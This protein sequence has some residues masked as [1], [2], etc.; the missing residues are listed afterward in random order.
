MLM[1]DK[2]LKVLVDGLAK[3]VTHDQIRRLGVL[4]PEYRIDPKAKGSGAPIGE[5]VQ[6]YQ[7]STTM[8]TQQA[9]DRIRDPKE[10]ATVEAILAKHAALP[11]APQPSASAAPAPGTR[12][13]S[14]ATAK[15]EQAQDAQIAES[16]A[17]ITEKATEFAATTAKSNLLIVKH[18]KDLVA[19]NGESAETRVAAKKQ[20]DQMAEFFDVEIE[21]LTNPTAL[22]SWS[23]KLYG[24]GTVR[25]QAGISSDPIKLGSD[26]KHY[27]KHKDGMYT[28][29]TE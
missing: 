23:T 7:T 8:T 20:L 1:P 10:R 4:P 15:K 12:N 22:L 2:H 27:I 3:G 21:D 6:G 25:G 9:L 26:G 18:L 17:R 29:V 11:P 16:K 28:P 19:N 14:P 13:V 24:A 5:I